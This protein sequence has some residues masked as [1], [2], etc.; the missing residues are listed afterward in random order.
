VLASDAVTQLLHAIAGL[1]G[2]WC[3]VG[4]CC[5]VFLTPFL[6]LGATSVV[7]KFPLV[8]TRGGR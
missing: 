2:T 3:L 5:H 6:R 1:F 4:S 8:E 7:A